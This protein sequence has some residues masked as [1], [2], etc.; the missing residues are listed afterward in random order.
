MDSQLY[1]GRDRIWTKAVVST[2]DVV[3]SVVT[4][5]LREPQVTALHLLGPVRHLPGPPGPGEVGGGGP[6]QQGAG[7]LGGGA[8]SHDQ[9]VGGGDLE[10]GLDCKYNDEGEELLIPRASPRI[11]S[12]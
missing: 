11:F 10:D 12:L 4:S 2:T 1:L 5:N 8:F 6:R 3:T 9:V 7:Q